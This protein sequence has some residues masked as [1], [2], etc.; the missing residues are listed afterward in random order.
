[1]AEKSLNSIEEIIEIIGDVT[2]VFQTK[3]ERW[4]NLSP[5]ILV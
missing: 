4:K 2:I 5:I 1:M 3:R